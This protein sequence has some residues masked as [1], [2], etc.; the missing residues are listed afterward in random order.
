MQSNLRSSGGELRIVVCVKSVP[1]APVPRL[2]PDARIERSGDTRLSELDEHAV[3]QAVRLREE[4]IACELTYVTMGP[5]PAADAL[6][7]AL[8]MG[9]DRGLHVADDRLAGTDALGTSLVLARAI[10][11]AGFDL[12]LCGMA[13]TDAWM[14]VVPAMLA[15][16]LGLPQLTLAHELELDAGTATIARDDGTS[17]CRI[18]APLPVLVSV[19]DRIGPARYPS[20]KNVVAAKRKP[21]ETLT[22]DDL[23]LA[24]DAV[25]AAGA[26]TTVVAHAERPPRAAGIVVA[27]ADGAAHRLAEFLTERRLASVAA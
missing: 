5:R 26:A 4:G 6:R 13:A 18:A 14:G 7:K 19:T 12:V 8:A 16:R 3:E 22:L 11:R 10:E 15:E 20:F 23:G 24:P 25:G 21:I 2:G 17:A 1:D 27:E 9:G